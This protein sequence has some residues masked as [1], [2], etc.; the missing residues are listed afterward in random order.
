M[1]R[2][3]FLNIYPFSVR[4]STEDNF[5]FAD[6]S[7]EAA[8]FGWRWIGGKKPEDAKDTQPFWDK[9]KSGTL[10]ITY[11]ETGRNGRQ[12]IVDLQKLLGD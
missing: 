12:L 2:S 11:E 5:R 1:V 3:G 9:V 4:K 7:P 8:D 10:G 6:N